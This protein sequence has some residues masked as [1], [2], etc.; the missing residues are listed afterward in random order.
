MTWGEM[1]G[2][3]FVEFE[4]GRRLFAVELLFVVLRDDG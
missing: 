4:I 2:M 3:L 1:V